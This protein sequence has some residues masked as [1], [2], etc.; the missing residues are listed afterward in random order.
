MDADFILE[1]LTRKLDIYHGMMND[2][3][4]SI[5]GDHICYECAVS[6]ATI[7]MIDEAVKRWKEKL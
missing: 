5:N 7:Q 4:E 1:E 6:R 2:Y 3:D